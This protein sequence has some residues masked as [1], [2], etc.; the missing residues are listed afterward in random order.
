ML[1]SLG[2]LE[3][4]DWIAY[5]ALEGDIARMVTGSKGHVTAE[6]AAR[7]VWQIPG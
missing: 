3:Y 4:Q 6:M 5:Y 7:A 2:S 1:A